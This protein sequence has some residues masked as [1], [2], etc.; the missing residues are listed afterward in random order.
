MHEYHHL[1]QLTHRGI[2]V[3]TCKIVLL[4]FCIWTSNVSLSAYKMF[5][6][7]SYTVP[8]HLHDI[9]NFSNLRKHFQVNTCHFFTAKIWHHFSISWRL[10]QGP[11]LRVVAQFC[12]VFYYWIDVGWH[13]ECIS[14]LEEWHLTLFFKLMIPYTS[15]TTLEGTIW[16]LNNFLLKVP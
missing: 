10:R 15:N 11:F 7:K 13:L 6:F 9:T 8:V 2:Y 14:T 12:F 5:I 1:Q 3:T 4:L 16:Y